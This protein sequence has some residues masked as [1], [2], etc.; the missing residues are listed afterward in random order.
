MYLQNTMLVEVFVRN[1]TPE[2]ITISATVTG[3]DVVGPECILLPAGEKGV[4]ELTFQ[5]NVVGERKGR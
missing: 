1:P 2:D 3:R 5:P 4:Y